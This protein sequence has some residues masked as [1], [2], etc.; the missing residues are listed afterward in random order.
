MIA[1]KQQFQHSLHTVHVRM[2][3]RMHVVCMY[4]HTYIH[5]H[6]EI[7]LHRRCCHSLFKHTIGIGTTKMSPHLT[8]NYTKMTTPAGVS[9]GL[10]WGIV[11]LVNIQWQTV[12][13][14]PT[15]TPSSTRTACMGVGQLYQ[16][17]SLSVVIPLQE[18]LVTYYLYA[19]GQHNSRERRQE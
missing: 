7:R 12:L 4:I 14:T 13:T 10:H 15:R 19:V 8:L 2:Y 5:T 11:S 1:L 9:A 3:V 18:I 17:Y 16:Q 6:I